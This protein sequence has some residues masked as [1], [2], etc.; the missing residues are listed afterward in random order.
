MDSVK[1]IFHK[2]FIEYKCYTTFLLVLINVLVFLKMFVETGKLEFGT[3]YMY[4]K[5][6]LI[7]GYAEEG[8]YY[9]LISAMFLHF[10]FEHI[11]MNMFSLALLGSMTERYLGSGCFLFVYLLGG[12]SGSVF[13]AHI[14]QIHGEMVV[15]AGASGAI[16][17]I[18]G[19]LVVIFLMNRRMW[20]RTLATRI[21]IY[22]LLV[23]SE[24]FGRDG[25]DTN[26]HLGGF[27]TG[28]VLSAIVLLI[29]KG[30]VKNE[31]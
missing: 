27:V 12:L 4:N 20:D 26:A 21:G 29:K 25:V 23:F 8:E 7:P 16:Y 2:I 6:A 3:M 10:D 11:A 31:N 30:T 5:G 19:A 22:L 24:V 1:K 9:R 18:S 28:A 15:A 14:H 13:S 17:A